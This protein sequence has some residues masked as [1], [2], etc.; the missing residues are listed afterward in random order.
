MANVEKYL[1]ELDN[2]CWQ[3]PK[4][5]YN[6]IFV[7]DYAPNMDE[8]P[9]LEQDLSSWYQCLIGIIRWILEIGTVDIITE[10]SV[11]ASQMVMPRERHSETVLHVF[12]FLHHNYNTMMEFYT[13]YSATNMSGFK[14]CKLKDLYGE[15][16]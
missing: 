4:K 9:D 8:T 6:N 5:K 7:G 14:E 11:M 12:A 15:L 10:V 16:D 3:L 1:S 13:T 2:A